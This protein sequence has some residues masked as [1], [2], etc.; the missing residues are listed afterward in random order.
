MPS[1]A[2]STPGHAAKRDIAG[3]A[4]PFRQPAGESRGQILDEVV[5]SSP[6]DLPAP[7]QS[8]DGQ[9]PEAQQTEETRGGGDGLPDAVLAQYADP[10]TEGSLIAKFRSPDNLR[11]VVAGGT[12][13]RFSALIPGWPFHDSP[14]R[15]VIKKIAA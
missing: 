13:G 6:T 4:E 2:D 14:A 8:G 1:D 7:D 10:A 15:M 3:P 11:I 12:A 5:G 9:H